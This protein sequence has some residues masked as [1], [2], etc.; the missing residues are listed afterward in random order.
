M[1]DLESTLRIHLW[2]E[3]DEGMLF[4]IGRVILLKKIGELGS[5]NKAAKK[6]GMSYRAAWGKIKATERELGVELITKSPDSRG[7]GL[8]PFGYQLLDDFDRWH[9][10]IESIALE[11]AKTVF[12]WQIHPFKE[13]DKSPFS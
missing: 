2:L 13:S 8:T 1:K 5:L 11:K 10:E 9:R 12:P 3:T 4:G 7:F 6:M